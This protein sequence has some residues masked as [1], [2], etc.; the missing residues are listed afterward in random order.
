MQLITIK[1]IKKTDEFNDVQPDV[2]SD[3]LIESNHI[4][5]CESVLP[6]LTIKLNNRQET[7]K[8]HKIKAVIRFHTPSK[9]K[10]PEKFYH[11]LLMLYFPWRKES[12]LLGDDQ[13]YSTKFQEPQVFSKVETNRR[14]FEPN[15][16]AIDAA[17]Q[18]VRENRLRDFQSYDRINE[19]ENDAL[20]AEAMNSI[21]DECD[22]DLPEELV[23][24]PPETS[25]TV[26]GIATYNQPSAIK[27]EELRDAVRSLNVK[28]RIT[29]DVVLSWCRNSIKSV[30]C[31][32]KETIEP[33]HIFVTGGGGGGDGKSHLIKT[34]YHTAV[35]M[36]KYIAVNPSLP[37]VIK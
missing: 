11:H 27:D 28:Q 31:L 20:S 12:D 23:S 33:I 3:D 19:Q 34:I 10:E 26:A 32:T 8:R 6:P 4:S 35:N 21:D 24:L 2:L 1:T 18:M 22:N 37:T 5:N 29:Y 15:A 13:L 7:M 36:F 14:M 9:A 17:L 16:E 25:Q 30:N